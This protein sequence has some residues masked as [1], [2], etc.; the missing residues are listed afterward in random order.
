MFSLLLFIVEREGRHRVIDIADKSHSVLGL[1]GERDLFHADPTLDA[2]DD[3][4]LAACQS[5]NFGDRGSWFLCFR[6][7]ISGMLSRRAGAD[8]HYRIL[9]EWVAAVPLRDHEH[10]LAVCLFCMDSAVEC[11]VFALNAIGFGVGTASFLDVSDHKALRRISPENIIGIPEKRIAGYDVLF[12]NLAQLWRRNEADIRMIMSNHEVA[13]HRH[14]NFW[15]GHHREDP[16]PEL[17]QAFGVRSSTELPFPLQP[18]RQVLLPRQP[19]LPLRDLPGDLAHWVELQEIKDHFDNLMK[20]T[21]EIA[22]N[23]LRSKV[24]LPHPISP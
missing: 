4:A 8:R 12:P 3:L 21:A 14:S 13:K 11:W 9:T 5:S 15:G 17:L 18:M 16:P 24:V 19:K 2:L 22:L 7:A 23:D 6:L 1:G 20:Q 10:E